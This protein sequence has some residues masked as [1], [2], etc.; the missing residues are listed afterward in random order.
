MDKNIF[1]IVED[2]LKTNSKYLSED[3]K[4]L[5]AVVYSDVM[6]M[7]EDLLLLLLSEATIKERFFK[8]IKGTLVFD[9]QKFAWF[10]ESKEF[11]PD[12]YTRYTN[13]IGLTHGGDFISKSNDVVLDFP[14]KDCVLEGGQDKEDQKRKEIFY[15]ETIA[16][17]EISKMLAPKVFTN[18]KRYTKDGIEENITFDENDNLIIKGNNLIAL[19]SLLK[20][21]EGKVKCI[22]ID[23]P[24]NTNNDTNNTF[25][26]NNNFNHST[27][28]TF[29]RNRLE[30][31]KRLLIPNEGAMIIAIDEN[32][33]AYLGVMLDELFN[34]YESH[35]ITVVHNPRGVQGT[36]FSYTNEFLY[37]VIPKGKKIIQNRKLDDEEIEFSPLRNWGS[38]SLR[39]DAKNCFYP[40]LVKNGEI[41]GFGDVIE[42][43]VHPSANEI[44]DNTTYIY[45]IDIKGVE[46]KWRYAR[47]SV[48]DIKYLLRVFNRKD[49]FLDIELGKDFGQYK[50]VWIDKKFDANAY[51]KQW[52]NK[53]VDDKSFSFPKSIYAVKEAIFSIVSK[54]KQAIILDFF[55]G[56]GTSAEAV[57]MINNVDNGNRKFIIIEQMDYIESITR[58]RIVNSTVNGK[59]STLVYCELLE[60]VSTLIEKIQTASEET[61]SEI[62]NEI[63]SDERIVPYITR[64]ELEKADEEFNSLELEEKKKALINL[65]DK[66]KLYVNY[67]DMDDE[68]Y[69]ISESDKAFTKSFYAE[70]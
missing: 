47:N 34:E 18:A 3:G 70:V 50:T 36:N 44:V 58:E 39:T 14:Y 11:L 69:A 59:E 64:A 37:F 23:P 28:L 17:D 35:M 30:I 4:L 25:K 19:S 55:G 68:S 31:A 13:K 38:E 51:G 66:N 54:N 12:S 40:I 63:Y 57:S 1:G 8:N 52:L 49:G 5:K 9:K 42:D 29:M 26:Y 27:W 65:V 20:R 41:I 16:S 33:Q 43:D 32:E 56:S 24:Y 21:Y 60:N 22:Y 7:D 45:P 62:K 10:I 67:S 48:E 46:R 6:M 15:N 53:I 2:V 61:I